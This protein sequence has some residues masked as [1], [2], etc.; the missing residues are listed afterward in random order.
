VGRDWD[1]R[2]AYA[3]GRA[4]ACF[5]RERGEAK[6]ILGRDNRISSQSIY[7]NFLKGLVELGLEITDLGLTTTP[8][9]YWARIHL[10][11][12]GSAMVTGSHNPLEW[13]GLKLC[14]KGKTTLFGKDM[15]R[16]KQ[17][18]FEKEETFAHFRQNGMITKLDTRNDYIT[19]IVKHLPKVDS[20]LKPKVVVDSGN[21]MAGSYIKE[22]LK[23]LNCGI[24]TLHSRMDGT[25]PNHMPDP[26][27]GENILELVHAVVG[28]K[29]D[30]GIAFDGDVDRINVIDNTGYAL[31]G[32]GVLAFLAKDILKNGSAGRV[33]CKIL[34]NTQCSPAIYD[35]IKKWGG[36]PDIIPTGHARVSEELDMED[37]VLAGEYKGHI[38]F[39][40]LYY[41]F[42]DALYAAA[43]VV[44]AL[45]RFGKTSISDLMNDVDSYFSTGEVAIP[46][47]DARKFELER[48]MERAIAKDYK[49][50]IFDGD[51]RIDFGDNSYGLARNSDTAPKFEI[52]AW[53]KDVKTLGKRRDYLVNLVQELLAVE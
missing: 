21:G 7:E 6:V 30:L 18:S 22:I 11:I 41:P 10:K 38:F 52:Y 28:N 29:A 14:H 9:V 46:T 16:I 44:T 3:I 47:T 33:G 35:A 45:R 40:D 31:W 48:E 27:K 13:N 4:F 5:L 32:D 24:F 26:S 2:D 8:Q 20:A 51:I 17:L 1:T 12:P 23:R 53:A 15:E 36:D 42:D 25:F 37:E 43:R 50:G 19:D 49:I 39:N 34:L